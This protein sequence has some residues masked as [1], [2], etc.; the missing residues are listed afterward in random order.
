VEPEGNEMN[1][2]SAKDSHE[3]GV[4][5]RTSYETDVGM[6]GIDVGAFILEFE[7]LVRTP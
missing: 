3:I 7:I 6:T 1:S 2:N 5:W 4:S